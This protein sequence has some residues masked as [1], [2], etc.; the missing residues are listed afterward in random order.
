MVPTAEGKR[1]ERENQA[2]AILSSMSNKG[3]LKVVEL[4][5]DE[6]QQIKEYDN[7]LTKSTLEWSTITSRQ[8]KRSIRR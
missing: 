7:S 1:I 4:K 5:K 8:F 2:K 3:L 6:F